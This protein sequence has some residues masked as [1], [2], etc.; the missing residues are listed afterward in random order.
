ME[1][2]LSCSAKELHSQI[3]RFMGYPSSHVAPRWAETIISEKTPVAQGLN[4]PMEFGAIV[5]DKSK[6]GPLIEIT[7]PKRKFEAAA[8]ILTSIGKATEE[9]VSSLMGAG[10]VLKAM[11]LDA[12][13]TVLLTNLAS[14]CFDRVS[15]ESAKRGFYHCGCLSPGE[16]DVPLRLQKYILGN[17]PE[18]ASHIS[19]SDALMLTPKKSLSSI[20]LLSREKVQESFKLPCAACTLEDCQF[21]RIEEK[22]IAEN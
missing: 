13:G 6:L 22:N 19:L 16:G 18:A 9:E 14:K 20:I 3:L 15:Q 11:V 12:I 8:L 2:S 4:N 1:G 7:E 17:L 21:R 5:S 10:K